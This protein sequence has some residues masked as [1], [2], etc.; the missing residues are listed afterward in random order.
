M[1]PRLYTESKSARRRR[2]RSRRSPNRGRSV[3]AARPHWSDG[4]PPPALEYAALQ[5]LAT[6]LRLHPVHEAVSAQPPALLR[7]IRSL[8]HFWGASVLK[9]RCRMSG[10]TGRFGAFRQRRA[11]GDMARRQKLYGR[12]GGRVNSRTPGQKC[13]CSV[14]RPAR[15]GRGACLVRL[16]GRPGA[17]PRSWRGHSPGQY[18]PPLAHRA[19]MGEGPGGGFA[20]CFS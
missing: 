11:D 3:I 10:M 5:H 2:R 18:R 14:F 15:P 1:R 19:T 13:S 8:G 9:C 4:E 17:T 7:L 6:V 16:I 20:Q 12:V